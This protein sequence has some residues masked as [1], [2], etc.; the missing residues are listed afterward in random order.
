MDPAAPRRRDG[1]VFVVGDH[2]AHRYPPTLFDVAGER[3][4]ESGVAAARGVQGQDPAAV[5]HRGGPVEPG[6][7]AVDGGGQAGAVGARPAEVGGELLGCRVDHVL[8][9][10]QDF[11]EPA[12]LGGVRGEV[13]PRVRVGE[14]PVAGPVGPVGHAPEEDAGEGGVDRRGV[15]AVGEVVGEA[16]W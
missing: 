6:R 9:V 3:F 10:A 1:E 15:G 12:A 13:G 8:D 5:L 7:G 14:A 16:W 2:A 11:V 4:V